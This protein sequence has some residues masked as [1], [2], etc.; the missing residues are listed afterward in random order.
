MLDFESRIAICLLA[1][2]HISAAVF[3]HLEEGGILLFNRLH[4][5]RTTVWNK[6]VCYLYLGYFQCSLLSRYSLQQ[7]IL[8]FISTHSK[9]AL[10]VMMAIMNDSVIWM[11]HSDMHSSPTIFFFNQLPPAILNEKKKTFLFLCFNF[12]SN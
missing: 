3:F 10:A 1:A 9:N 11:N 7:N 8:V 5:K 12:N 4:W 2:L 6:I